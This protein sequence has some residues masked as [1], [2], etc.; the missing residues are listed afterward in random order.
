LGLTALGSNVVTQES[1]SALVGA[2]DHREICRI[3]LTRQSEQW[4]NILTFSNEA[5]VYLTFVKIK[6]N[7]LETHFFL[8]DIAG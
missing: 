4:K 8:F 1:Q 2:G 7:V 3:P 6:S 5:D